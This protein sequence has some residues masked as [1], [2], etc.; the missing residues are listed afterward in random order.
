MKQILF[1]AII[2]IFSEFLHAQTILERYQKA[3][4]FLPKNSVKLTKNVN[5][6]SNEIEGTNDFWYKLQTETGDKYMFLMAIK[7]N[8]MK[9]LIIAGFLH[10]FP[11][12]WEKL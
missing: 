2:L 12:W 1:L 3:E 5:I 9:H 6:R 11:D 8:R 4:Q 7:R 10:R